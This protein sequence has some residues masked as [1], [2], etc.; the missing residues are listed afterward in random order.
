MMV[1]M[2]SPKRSNHIPPGMQ[3]QMFNNS[4]KHLH[5]SY[6]PLAARVR[7]EKIENIYGHDELLN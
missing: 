4:G 3:Q 7:P 6:M 5:H 1:Y 2:K